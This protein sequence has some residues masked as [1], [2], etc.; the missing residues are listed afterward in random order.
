MARFQMEL[1]LMVLGSLHGWPDVLDWVMVLDVAEALVV[2]MVPQMA[3]Q[4]ERRVIPLE[5][6]EAG[7]V[8]IEGI[9]GWAAPAVDGGTM[10]DAPFLITKGNAAIRA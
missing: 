9:E 8:I 7:A 5:A 4:S 3:K 6:P 1:V 2:S 10:C